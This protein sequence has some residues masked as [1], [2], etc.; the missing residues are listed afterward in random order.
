MEQ[1]RQRQKCGGAADLAAGGGY[2][3]AAAAGQREREGGPGAALFKGGEEEAWGRGQR[4][5]P[6]VRRLRRAVAAADS[7]LESVA[8][9][10]GAARRDFFLKRLFLQ[11]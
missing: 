1:L 2:A 3:G 8:R 9:G 10:D 5:S 4:R 6:A 7:R 11:K